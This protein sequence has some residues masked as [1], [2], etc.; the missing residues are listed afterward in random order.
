MHKETEKT[1]YKT[2]LPSAVDGNKV[3]LLYGYYKIEVV[4]N[5]AIVVCG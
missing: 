3:V 5:V 1:Q 4:D 2:I